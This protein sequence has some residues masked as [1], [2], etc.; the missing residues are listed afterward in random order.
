MEKK[1][2]QVTKVEITIAGSLS[3]AELDKTTG[4]IISVKLSGNH[5]YSDD[6]TRDLFAA[7][8][9]QKA[10]EEEVKK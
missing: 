4:D 5:M 1:V 9:L 7:S 8:Q 10:L 2:T 3:V 6:F